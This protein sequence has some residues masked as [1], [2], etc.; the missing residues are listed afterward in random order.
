MIAQL[1]LPAFAAFDFGMGMLGLPRVG[2]QQKENEKQGRKQLNA[3]E[4]ILR[5]CFSNL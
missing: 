3:D 1:P 4:I 2:E 5:Y